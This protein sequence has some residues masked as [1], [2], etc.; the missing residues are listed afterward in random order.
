MDEAAIIA[1]TPAPNT[2]E[3]LAGDLRRLGVEPGMTLLV[4]TSLSSIGWVAGGPVAVVQALLD[5]LTPAGTLVMPAHSSDLSD[6]ARWQNP[7]VPADWVPIVRDALPAYDPR[8]T[9]AR[10]MGRV[11]ETFRT[12]PGVSRSAHPQVSFAAWGRYAA[13]VTEGHALDDSLGEGSPLARVYDLDGHV[14]LLGAGYDSNT[15]FHLAEYRA[16]VAAGIPQGAP[17]LEAGERVWRE[18]M[19]IDLD[20][21]PFAELGADFERERPEVVRHGRVGLAEARL[22]RQRPAVDFATAWLRQRRGSQG[23]T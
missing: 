10:G 18:Y 9:P 19:D 6:P 23:I 11:A 4:H 21:D 12:W 16:P 20:D 8:V 13:L 2:R 15:S 1:R 7:P 17:M 22:F 5:A 14:L 3:S